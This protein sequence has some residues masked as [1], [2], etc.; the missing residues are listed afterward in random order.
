ML[1]I[2][3][4]GGIA[5][6]KSIVAQMFVDL[7]AALVDTDQLAREVVAPGQP[8]LDAIRKVFGP[9]VLTEQGTLDR[10]AMRQLVFQDP[11][12]R[13][14]LETILHPRIRSL[15]LERVAQARGAYTVAA[16]PLLVESEFVEMFDRVLVVD[17]PEATQLERLIHRDGMEEAE[18]RAILAAQADRQTRLDAADDVID[19]SGSLEATRRQVEELHRRYLQLAAEAD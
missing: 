12:K 8:G 14:T 1:T 6:G 11:H 18:A 3:L 16:V 17:C 13:K 9:R 5:S 15:M 19:N 4:T 2:G 7:G 10:A